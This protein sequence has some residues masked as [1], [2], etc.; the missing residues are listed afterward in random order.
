MFALEAAMRAGEIINARWTDIDWDRCV[1]RLP[2]T[3]TGVPRDV[4]LSAKT[5]ATGTTRPGTIGLV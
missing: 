3:K 4:P 1:I 2:R 5:L